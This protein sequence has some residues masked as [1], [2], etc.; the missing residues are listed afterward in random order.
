VK[1]K[2][3]CFCG[4]LPLLSCFGNCS[5]HVPLFYL[6]L[7]LPTAS[8][9]PAVLRAPSKLFHTCSF[10]GVLEM[11]Y[12]HR[13]ASSELENACACVWQGCVSPYSGTITWEA[14]P[15]YL[16]TGRGRRENSVGRQSRI[17]PCH[18]S[19]LPAFLSGKELFQYYF[20]K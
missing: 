3:T 13:D 18:I 12:L 14:S 11:M 10:F 16:A 19:W 4:N 17:W 15:V 6:W 9:I 20:A 1:Y 7:Q 5:H 2:Y 8:A